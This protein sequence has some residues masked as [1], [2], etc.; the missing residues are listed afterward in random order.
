MFHHRIENTWSAS[1]V[2]REV[3]RRPH[4]LT[5]V[6]VTG[7]FVHRATVPVV[8]IAGEATIN[9][10]FAEISADGKELRG[11]F[12]DRLP[13]AGFVEF[14]YADEPLQRL[15]LRWEDKAIVRLDRK[16]LTVA[17]TLR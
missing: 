1:E 12:R 13:H 17:K 9:C 5:R 4:L 3:D 14:G 15:P 11:Y 2:I 16:R 7:R 10:W 6:T 8:R